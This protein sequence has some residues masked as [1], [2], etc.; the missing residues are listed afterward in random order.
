M[1]ITPLGDSALIVRLCDRFED[2]PSLALNCVLEALRRLEDAQLPGVIELAPAYTTV[3]V[4]FDPV[5][6]A[7]ASDSATAP[8]EWLEIR[9]R[10]T[11]SRNVDS[12]S[13]A[14]ESRLITIPVCYGGEFGPD[15][16]EVARHAGAS[17]EDIVQRHSAVEYR[18]HCLGFSPGFPYLGGLPL[19]LAVPRRAPRKIV[20]PG[21]VGIGG[22]QTGIYPL[23]SP[24]GWHL[25]GRTP[26][27]LFN[28][29]TD[30]PTLL[31][32]GDRVRFLAITREEF[33]Q[34]TE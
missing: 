8:D 7:E 11:L 13:I 20:P 16:H 23:A 17:T 33:D 4:Y 26:I 19:E 10:E 29:E 27:R 15:L 6:V 5:A 14:I 31:H 2:D 28:V 34:W 25:I 32:A 21:S 9:I 1:Q 24:G 30:P 12:S 18:V 3:A 22:A